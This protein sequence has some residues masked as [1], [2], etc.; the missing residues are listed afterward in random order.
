MKLTT[1]KTLWIFTMA[2]FVSLL[3]LVV[4]SRIKLT[5]EVVIGGA[6]NAFVETSDIKDALDGYDEVGNIQVKAPEGLKY[7]HVDI[8]EW[9]YMLANKN[10]SIYEYSPELKTASQD[11]VYFYTLAVGYL[12]DM[13]KAAKEEGFTPYVSASYKSYSAQKQL[14]NEKVEELIGNSGYSREEAEEIAVKSVEYPGTNEHQTGLAVD[15]LDQYYDEIPAYGSMDSEFYAWLDEHCAEYGFIK[16]YPS[17]LK[18]L[19]GYDEPWH[20]RFVGKEA[21]AFIMN[22]GLCLEQFEAYY[23]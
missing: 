6:D 19:T 21:A 9:R 20:Y 10:N 12:N 13:L 22:N 8:E 2:I 7:P 23:K 1:K 14:F 18:T 4:N 17:E 11:G 3:V 15:I 16:R 5:S